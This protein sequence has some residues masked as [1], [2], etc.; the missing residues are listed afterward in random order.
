MVVI[1]LSLSQL[2]NFRFV[3][4][5]LD[6]L[7]QLSLDNTFWVCVVIS[8]W[9]CEPCF[10]ILLYH[11]NQISGLEFDLVPIKPALANMGY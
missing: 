4:H 10:S 2:S 1:S 7:G 5:D 11:A 6:H 9:I 3:L 8:L